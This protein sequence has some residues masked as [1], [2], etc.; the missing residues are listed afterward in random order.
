MK[1]N[2]VV[3]SIILAG[4]AAL[5]LVA[6]AT[7]AL[8]AATATAEAKGQVLKPIGVT[9]TTNLDFGRFMSG[10]S[11]GTIAVS[12]AG[13]ASV[14][15]GV[16]EITGNVPVAAKFDVTGEATTGFSISMPATVT[17]TNTTGGGNE[18]MV[19]TL[20]KDAVATAGSGTLDGSGKL[21]VY[22][23]G[24]LAVGMN[25]VSG[26]YKNTTDFTVTVDY[27]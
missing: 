7:V 3:K 6:Q 19:V 26:L 8:A 10:G 27:N 13:S 11:T 15:G 16:T 22:V 5:F 14:T 23:G 1:A 24:S 2:S 20:A 12:A 4:T 9:A 18:T 17:L 25:Q 21:S